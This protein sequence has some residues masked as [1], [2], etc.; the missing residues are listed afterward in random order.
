MSTSVA[1][2]VILAD[3]GVD[4]LGLR[5]EGT[6]LLGERL[7][8]LVAAA[9]DDDFGALLAKATA[10]ARPMPVSAPVIKTTCALILRSL[11]GP[12]NPGV[13]MNESCLFHRAGRRLGM[14]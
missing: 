5:T 12:G 6:Q 10:A 9:G 1:K 2:V 8:G 7:A 14:G 3:V 13:S 4:E 11:V